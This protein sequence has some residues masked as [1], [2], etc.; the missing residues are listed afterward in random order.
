MG[1]SSASGPVAGNIYTIPFYTGLV[2]ITADKIDVWRM[3]WPAKIVHISAVCNSTTGGTYDIASSV[4]DIVADRTIPTTLEQAF[5][6]ASGS[7]L[8]D[9]DAVA[10]ANRVLAENTSLTVT[11]NVGTNIANG[12]IMVT[13]FTT[14]QPT[15]WAD[16]LD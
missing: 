4:G 9:I 6:G 3:G 11:F 1:R 12:V 16:G 8:F 14:G 10:A 5:P 13:L 2:A 15:R 7:N